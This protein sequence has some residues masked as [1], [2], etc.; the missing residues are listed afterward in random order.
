MRN[1]LTFLLGTITHAQ[2]N[3]S[4]LAFQNL[5]DAYSTRAQQNSSRLVKK[6]HQQ[7]ESLG[8][9]QLDHASSE[10]VNYRRQ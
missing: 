8:H 4:H 9:L 1:Y 3:L 6:V 5:P 7:L 2:P 10:P